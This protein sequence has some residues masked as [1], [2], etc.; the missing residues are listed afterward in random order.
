VTNCKLQGQ[1]PAH[2]PPLGAG[3]VRR[4]SWICAAVLT[5]VLAAGAAYAYTTAGGS[6]SGSGATG[7]MQPVTIAAF[8]GGAAPGST[9][10]PGGTA[11]V[12]I[13]VNNPNPVPVRVFAVAANGPV[14]AD[15]SHPGCTTTGVTFVD[16]SAPISPAIN[17]ASGSTVLIQVPDA[18]SMDL[19][20][21]PECQGA[22]FEIPVSLTVHR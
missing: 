1:L 5:A 6:G 22:S 4:A 21:L 15:A 3:F 19:T 20:S 13:R 12:T 10:I 16:P 18:A 8:T 2:S 17:V 14:S 7:T 11:D 9:L